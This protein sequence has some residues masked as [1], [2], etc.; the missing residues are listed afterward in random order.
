MANISVEHVDD[1]K[2]KSKGRS[3]K[4]V[5]SK[6]GALVA[7]LMVALIAA[8]VF[9]ITDRA[10]LSRE[11]SKLSEAQSQQQTPEDE[12]EQLVGEVSRLIEL[13]SDETPTIA[14]VTDSTKVK[15]KAFFANAQNG[16]KVLLYAKASKAVLYRPST[17]KLIEVSVLNLS[18][19][20]PT[21]QTQSTS[22]TNR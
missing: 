3:K 18:E 15:D 4:R 19:A 6:K 12:A 16:D 22:K 5:V 2:P 21:T 14:T 7:V 20:E 17:H 1:D 11:V 13:P 10:R 9:L 8:A